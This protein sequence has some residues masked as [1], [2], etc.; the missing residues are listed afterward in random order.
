MWRNWSLIIKYWVNFIH[1]QYQRIQLAYTDYNRHRGN[2]L[3]GSTHITKHNKLVEIMRTLNTKNLTMQRNISTLF[4][5]T[6]RIAWCRF[7]GK[8]LVVYVHAGRLHC[9][10]RTVHPHRTSDPPCICPLQKH[11]NQEVYTV[12]KTK[13]L[14]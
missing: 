3:T 12:L 10:T 8:R 7:T 9:N 11:T 4:M 14:L 1:Y 13:N 6:C 5:Y 2:Q